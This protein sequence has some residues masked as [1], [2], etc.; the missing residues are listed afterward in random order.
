M[1]WEYEEITEKILRMLKYKLI[2]NSFSIISID[3]P[4]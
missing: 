3:L 2:Y 1:N 4:K